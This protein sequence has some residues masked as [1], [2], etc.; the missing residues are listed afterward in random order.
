[1]LRRSISHEQVEC[2]HIAE[3]YRVSV[4]KLP[5]FGDVLKRSK[6]FSQVLS[7][8]CLLQRFMSAPEVLGYLTGYSWG[9]PA[10]LT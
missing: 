10:V 1:M 5:D 9:P 3:K 7:I 2:L 4:I 6:R 8:S